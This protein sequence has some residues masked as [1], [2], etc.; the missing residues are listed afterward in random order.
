ML[1]LIPATLAIIALAVVVWRLER[2]VSK[3]PA[4]IVVPL[5][6]PAPLPTV[7]AGDNG[8]AAVV[9]MLGR[10]EAA[11]HAVAGAVQSAMQAVDSRLTE[12]K[13]ALMSA[14]GELV[15]HPVQLVE[16]D[17]TKILQAVRTELKALPQQAGGVMSDIRFD[18]AGLIA[19]AEE[20]ATGIATQALK[21]TAEKLAAFEARVQQLEDNAVYVGNKILAA[22]AVA[23]A[24][25]VSAK[26]VK[27]HPES[28]AMGHDEKM[29]NA[30][31]YVAAQ[32]PG[33]DTSIFRQLIEA[34]LGADKLPV[35]PVVG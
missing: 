4:P 6:A 14:V 10:L 28:G 9:E 32:K 11:Q 15:G 17:V 27:L 35:A 23:H 29:R 8:N 1:W 22:D 34:V 25:Q 21:S 13:T 33:A 7:A 5:P 16:A 2:A 19:K 18:T 31:D 3:K 12:S 26:N 30:L 24:E 20:I